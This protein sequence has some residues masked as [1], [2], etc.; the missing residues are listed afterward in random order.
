[1]LIRQ[2]ILKT[3][4]LSLVISF[5]CFAV[6]H[7]LFPEKFRFV[8]SLLPILFGVINILIFISLYKVRESSLSKFSNRYLLSTTVKLLGSL[9]FIIIYLFINRNDV[10]PFVATFLS[11]YFI[12]LFHEIV[13][14]LNFF[15]KKEK[16]EASHSK[17]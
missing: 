3:I 8:Y 15:K 9:F 7:Y 17:T 13:S 11:I 5:L 12:F 4:A 10:I 16:S 2:F 1:M 6:F 14:I